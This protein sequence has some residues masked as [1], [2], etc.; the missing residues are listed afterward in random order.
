MLSPSRDEVPINPRYVLPPNRG[1][2][3]RVVRLR[4]AGGRVRPTGDGCAAVS[5]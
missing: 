3:G 4:V 1:L 2:A 5:A